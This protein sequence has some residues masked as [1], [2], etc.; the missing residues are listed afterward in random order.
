MTCNV[1]RTLL[2]YWT[3]YVDSEGELYICVA[4]CL[5]ELR[6][7]RNRMLRVCHKPVSKVEEITIVNSV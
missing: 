6:T 5:L 7:Q 1:Q 4:L 2:Q 3:G